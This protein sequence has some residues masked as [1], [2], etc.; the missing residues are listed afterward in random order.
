MRQGFGIA[1]LVVVIL[2][3]F[4]PLYSFIV[5]GLALILAAVAALAGDRPFAIATPLIAA[6]NFLLL[7]PVALAYVDSHSGAWLIVLIFLALPFAAISLN[8]SGKVV[9]GE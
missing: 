4:V 1:A 5:S 9:L 3:I 7:S 2:A 8:S 6:A